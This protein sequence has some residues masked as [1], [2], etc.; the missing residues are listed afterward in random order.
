MATLTIKVP[1][2]IRIQD[3]ELICGAEAI[4]LRRG[5]VLVGRSRHCGLSINDPSVSSVHCEVQVT[6]DGARIRDLGSRNGTWVGGARIRE[7]TL[8]DVC[9]LTVGTVPVVFRPSAEVVVSLGDTAFGPL[10]AV[11]PP[12]RKVFLV[13]REV[14]ESRLNVLLSGESGTGKDL[15]A[16]AIHAASPR[17]GGPY[18]VVPC[19]GMTEEMGR[20]ILYGKDGRRGAIEEASDG[21]LVLDE[22]ADLPQGVQSALFTTLTT[23][24]YADRIRV[25]STSRRQLSGVLN[26]GS[27]RAD[28]FFLLAQV[29]VELPPL[30]ERRADAL[31]IVNDLWERDARP[32]TVDRLL[33]M[34]EERFSHYDWPGNVRELLNVVMAASQ[35]PESLP[36]L[37]MQLPL[38]SSTQ[39]PALS[40]FSDAKRSALDAFERTYFSALASAAQSNISEM[41]R[42]SGLARHHVRAYLRKFGL[43]HDDG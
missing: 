27:F 14:S 38:E 5:A 22:V 17:A 39:A 40:A 35:L 41:S 23:A 8:H 30:R 15:A 31:A 3:C 33:R 2:E 26:A 43:I 10:V 37:S 4:P 24:P 6:A 7:A 12:M 13:L 16:T 42:R 21:T 25:L 20:D 32:G 9:T 34:L 29:R 18:V 19:T 1:R 36:W 11:A 28:L